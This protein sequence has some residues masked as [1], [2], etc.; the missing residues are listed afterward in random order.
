MP[1]SLCF[2]VIMLST[3]SVVGVLLPYISPPM[4]TNLPRIRPFGTGCVFSI[5]FLHLLPDALEATQKVEMPQWLGN[6]PLAEGLCVLGFLVMVVVEQVFACPSCEIEA[7]TTQ[8][9][10]A[11]DNNCHHSASQHSPEFTGYSST[12]PQPGENAT[13]LPMHEQKQTTSSSSSSS[14]SSISP[15]ALYKM[16]MLEISIAVHSILVGLPLSASS[17]DSL[18]WALGFHQ[19]FEGMSLGLAGLGIKL[20]LNGFV[21]LGV[22]FG[23]S[24]SSGVMAGYFVSSLAE[25]TWQAYT[26]SLA[27]GIVLYVAIEF[28][29]KDFGHHTN[30]HEGKAEKLSAFFLGI[31][32]MAV[33]AIWA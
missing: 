1:Y 31:A 33:M 20:D 22:L 15:E 28:Y 27:A 23:L 4:K 14:S 7:C 30:K 12:A 19:L 24:I 9:C 5:A 17:S 21:K 32:V 8:D 25:G 26:N 16:Y 18:V 13:L 29:E 2:K 6:F 10:K 11:P 3:L